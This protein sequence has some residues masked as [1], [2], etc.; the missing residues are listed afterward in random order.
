MSEH[1][2]ILEFK[3]PNRAAQSY[4]DAITIPN[5]PSQGSLRKTTK[6]ITFWDPPITLPQCTFSPCGSS[7]PSSLRKTMKTVWFRDPISNCISNA[8]PKRPSHSSNKQP[9]SALKPCKTCPPS[10]KPKSVLKPLKPK[11]TETP[12]ST[13]VAQN[14]VTL[15]CPIH[16]LS[17]LTLLFPQSN[18][19]EGRYP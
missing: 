1:L 15:T 12:S 3:V 10:T 4:I 19:P 18:M 9:I 8:M 6:C 16:T 2:G 11:P 13:A 17:G 14:I 5:S 7:L